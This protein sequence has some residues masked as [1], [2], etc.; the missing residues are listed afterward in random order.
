PDQRPRLVVGHSRKPFAA[1]DSVERRDEIG[2]R[3]DEGAIEIEDDGGHAATHSDEM[4]RHSPYSALPFP[5]KLR[6]PSCER[7]KK[8]GFST[9]REASS[10]GEPRLQAS[11]MGVSAREPDWCATREWIAA[12]SRLRAPGL[13]CSRNSESAPAR[14]ASTRTPS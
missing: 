7:V 13:L 11:S 9:C 5:A 6:P 10:G 4:E 2:R 8:T 1:Q 14:L 12:A 3:I